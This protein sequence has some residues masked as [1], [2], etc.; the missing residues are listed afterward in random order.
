MSLRFA[1]LG[2][3]HRHIYGMAGNMIVAGAEFVGWWTDGNPGTLDGFDKR[4][5][6]VPRAMDKAQ[7]LDDP[8]I[9]LIL[10]SAI[11]RDRAALAIAAMEAGKD[12]MVDKPG[13]TTLEQLEAIKACVAQTR[14]IWSVDFSE[15][16]EVPS[17]TRAAELVAEGA[18]GKVVQ[19]VG[20]GP[21]R[22]NR[23][24]RPDWFFERDAY[25]GI[26]TDIA[27]HQ[28]DQFL[29]F[30][31]ATDAEIT[32]ASVGNFA[33]PSDPGLQDFGEIALRAPEGHGYIR[34]DWYTPDAL[35][36]WGDGRLT[37][38]GTEGYI[39]LRKYVD[40]GGRDGTDHLVLVNGTRCENIDASDAGLPYFARLAADI[41]D[42]TETAM[43]QAH[44]FKVMELG[45]KAQE[46]AE[47]R[48]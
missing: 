8:T 13:C 27:S 32:L 6:G 21:H 3:D 7:L 19:T 40:V 24:T 47:A 29:Y 26:L 39:E 1:A 36:N 28:I 37:I 5:P 31:G 38:L 48:A 45:L 2:L 34:V 25:G 14:C 22:L 30:T 4:F 12:V 11:P 15:R 9:D 42:R 16:F 10:I 44:A 20:L 33:N 18:I 43:P 17:V 23:P 46:M 35:P 41:R